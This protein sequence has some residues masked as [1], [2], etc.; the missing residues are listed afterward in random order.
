MKR[1]FKVLI[2]IFAILIVAITGLIGYVKTALPD[3]AAA[4]DI[5]IDYTQERIAR[6]KYLANSVSMCIDCH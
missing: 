3:I 2:I 6:G 1:V 4:E 5:K